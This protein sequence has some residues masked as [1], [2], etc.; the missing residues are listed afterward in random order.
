MARAPGLS[1]R[2]KLT[3]S[4]AGFLMVAGALLLAVVWVFLL[5]Y[6]PD[7]ACRAAPSADPAP[8]APTSS[9]LRSEGGR[10]CW[11]SCSCSASLG[12]WLLA[13]RMLAPLTRITD[14]TRLAA[15]GSL[16]H[17]IQLEGRN[18]EFREL[19]D[20]FD[21]HARAARSA[22]R[23]AAEVRRQRLPR[24]AHPAGD[25]PDASRRRPQG[26]EPRQRRA[27]RPPPRR[28]HPGDRPHRG[29]APAQPR[30]P[31]VLRPRTRR[32]VPHRGGSRRDA[33]PPRGE[34]RRHHRDLRRH[35][36]DHRLTRAPAADDDEPRAQR[37]RPQP[38]RAGHRVGHDQRPAEGRGAHG[39]EH[40]R[41]S[42]PRS[43][44]P[45]SSSRSSAAPNAYAPT[46]RA[47]ASAWR[48]SRASPRHTTEP[49]PSPPG[50]PAGS[51]SR[52]E[53]P[54]APP[55]AGR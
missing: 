6:V 38:A 37:H 42:S 17:R 35:D 27:R 21:T 5:R 22:R 53:L 36:P 44:S 13:G 55:H 25:H 4:Y 9:R 33:P 7:R 31:A 12:G 40:R 48:S 41:R 24:A 49:S 51:A 1:V 2:L 32:P 30:R 29:A 47:S 8:T 11:R 28:Q 23:R 26:P 15:T 45:R 19:A 46:T 10:S 34:A 39:R 50:P 3:L 52:C 16:S 20:A 14:A 43:W 18:D 54:A